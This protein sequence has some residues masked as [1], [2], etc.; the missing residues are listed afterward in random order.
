[1]KK[2]YRQQ[3]GSLEDS[4]N[5][6]IEVNSLKDILDYVNKM[7]YKNLYCKNHCSNISTSFVGDDSTRCCNDWKETYYVLVDFGNY[8]QLCIGMCNFKD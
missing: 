7:M 8:K 4:L 2:L 5:T 3:N 1:M 6:S